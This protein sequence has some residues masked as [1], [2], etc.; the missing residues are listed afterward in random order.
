MGTDKALVEFDGRPLIDWAIGT[1]KAAGIVAR[2]AGARAEAVPRLRAYAP[3]V[4]D[5]EAGLG[6]LSGICA[7]LRSTPAAYA[8]FLAVDC[9]LLPSSLV[10]YLL[11]HAETAGALVTIASVNGLQ[12][13]FPAVIA[14]EALPALETRLRGPERACLASFHAAAAETRGMVS[15]LPVEMLAQSGQAAHPAG[16]PAVRWFLNVNTAGDLGLARRY[17]KL[18]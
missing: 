12:Q 6:P 4:P 16:L 10:A 2:I 9:P 18:A 3:V 13:T 17:G 15:V 7:G 1:L 11:R 14:R 5:E 8:V